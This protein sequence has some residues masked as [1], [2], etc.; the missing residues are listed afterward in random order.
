MIMKKFAIT[1]SLV[2]AAG[3][4][5]TS[6]LKDDDFRGNYFYPN[7]VVTAKTSEGGIFYLQL[8]DETTLKPTNLVKSPYGK[9]VRAFVNYSDQGAW[10]GPQE[11]GLKL[12]REVFLNAI[13]SIRTKDVVP[14]LGT[15]EDADEYGSAPI[16]IITN[17]WYTVLEDDYLT[18]TFTA[19]WN[20]PYIYHEINLVYGT[21]P[22]DP[23][24]VEL[25]HDPLDDTNYM[26]GL[27]STGVIAFRLTDL[28]EIGAR[29]DHLTIKY[30]SHDGEKSY[31]IER[32]K[33]GGEET[34]TKS[35]EKVSTELPL[36]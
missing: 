27:A 8:D 26:S 18:L 34:G 35:S 2:L 5:L 9:E 12:D 17:S 28:P 21:D 16:E 3:L 22:D 7:A 14:T 25:R 10:T 23:Y 30:I 33:A 4:M 15:E 11:E 13:D 1:A 19:R 24:V 36:R 32:K 20:N 6:C 29:P 31:T